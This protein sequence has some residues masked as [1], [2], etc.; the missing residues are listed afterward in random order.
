MPSLEHPISNEC[1]DES[2]CPA[3]RKCAN[4]PEDD[5]AENIPAY[6]PNTLRSG[7]SDDRCIDRVCRRERD[8]EFRD[9]KDDCR[10]GQLCGEPLHGVETN[11][12][13]PDSPHDLPAAKRGARSHGESTDNNYPQRYPVLISVPLNDKS[14]RENADKLL[15]VIEAMSPRHRGRRAHLQV[16]E[17]PLLPR[18]SHTEVRQRNRNASHEFADCKA[19]HASDT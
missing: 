16:I 19:Q 17:C 2:D 4:P 6:V 13:H 10:S 15:A 7:H 5:S 14:E 9:R 1:G 3:D 11:H 12:T 8:A 18:W